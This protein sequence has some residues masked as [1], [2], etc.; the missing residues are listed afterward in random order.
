MDD[1]EVCEICDAKETEFR[2]IFE[3][4]CQELQQKQYTSYETPKIL[5][6]LF[7]RYGLDSYLVKIDENISILR[8]TL[9]KR[10][11]AKKYLYEIAYQALLA[12]TMFEQEGEEK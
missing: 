2:Y 4:V 3:R 10:E 9:M 11:D 8:N 5:K 7:D 12:I 1:K 6:E